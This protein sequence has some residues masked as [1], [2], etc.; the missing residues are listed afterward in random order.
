MDQTIRFS[1]KN[2]VGQHWSKDNYK[3]NT[4]DFDTKVEK[5]KNKEIQFVILLATSAPAAKFINIAKTFETSHR[6]YSRPEDVTVHY[7]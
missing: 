4:L 7:S 1:V 6:G 3:R 2:C 5:F